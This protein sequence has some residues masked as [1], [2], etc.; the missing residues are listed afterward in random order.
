MTGSLPVVAGHTICRRC[1]V[2]QSLCRTLPPV[3]R[4]VPSPLL[5]LLARPL[6]S[7]AL[8]A[9]PKDGQQAKPA[10]QQP[11]AQNEGGAK[12]KKG[13]DEEGESMRMPEPHVS[14]SLCGS[15]WMDEQTG[16]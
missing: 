15:T 13:K 3:A 9:S 5:P 11:K 4:L 1:A 2:L 10:K 8:S 7:T 16:E 6:T 14:V 12:G